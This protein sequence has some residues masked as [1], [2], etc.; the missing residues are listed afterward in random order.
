MW[1]HEIATTAIVLET[2]VRA[3]GYWD[4]LQNRSG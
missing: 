1:R 4:M 3:A 2:E